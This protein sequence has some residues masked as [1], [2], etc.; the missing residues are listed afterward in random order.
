MKSLEDLPIDEGFLSEILNAVPSGIFVTDL[1]H[2]IVM[3]NKAGAELVGR[4]PGDCF[5]RKCYDIFNT[6]M[7]QTENCTCRVAVETQAVNQGQTTLHLPDGREVPIEYASRPLRNFEGKVVGCVEHYIDISDRLE[8]ERSLLEQQ[9]ELLR[10]QEADIRHLQDEILELST[11]VLEVWDGV[12][13]LPLVG[14]LDSR[15]AKIAMERLLEGIERTRA[16]FVILDITGV[17][18]VDAEVANH[19]LQTVDA[20]RLMGSRAVL[21]GVSPHI[22]RTMARLGVDMANITVRGRM[23]DALHMAIR[24]LRRQAGEEAPPGPGAPPAPEP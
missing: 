23:A 10:K 2:N 24:R 20:A 12:L 8:Q 4:S 11:P 21:T 5:D 13:A 17:P 15:R 14:T 7:C 19:L 3:I 1:E 6:P 22:A 9:E 16:P 18:A